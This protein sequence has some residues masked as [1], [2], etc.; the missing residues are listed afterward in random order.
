MIYGKLNL[1]HALYSG[2]LSFLLK[3]FHVYH[4]ILNLYLIVSFRSGEVRILGISL[5]LNG[6]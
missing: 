1:C 6:I 2:L 5:G 3:G 4:F